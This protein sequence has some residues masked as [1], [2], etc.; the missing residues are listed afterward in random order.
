MKKTIRKIITGLLLAFAAIQFASCGYEPVFYGIMNDVPPEAATVSGNIASVVRCTINSEEFLVLSNGG[1]LV[2]KPITSASHGEWKSDNIALPFSF[3]HYNYFKTKTED[4]GHIGQQVLKV[5]ADE[6]NIYLLTA[7][8]KQDNEYGVVLPETIYCW[9]C[10]LNSLLANNAELW[11]NIAQDNADLF[12]TIFDSS[13]S[14]LQMNFNL[15]FTNAPKPS[16]RKVFLSV[17]NDANETSYYTMNGANTPAAYSITNYAKLSDDSKK[18]A[19]A[20]YIGETI[21]FTD[22]LAAGTNET[23]ESNAT[24]ACIAGIKQNSNKKFDLY[25]FDGTNDPVNFVEFAA[26]VS[27][28]AFTANSLLIGKGNYSETYTSNCGIDRVLLD[29]DGKPQNEIADFENNAKYQFTSSYIV[30]SLLNTDPSKTEAESILY[31]TLSYR[32]SNNSSSASFNDVG[33]WSYYPARGN[34]NRE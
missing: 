9:T 26:P 7:S 28:L 25:S 3:H 13:T 20:F 30:M 23:A 31:A 34:W 19:S 17:T 5:A 4:E 8:F 1:S 22:S 33:L 14:Q 32:G 15:F 18:A 10:P 24:I 6:S 27:S 12:P 21:Y 2:Y 16:H 11:T 29:E